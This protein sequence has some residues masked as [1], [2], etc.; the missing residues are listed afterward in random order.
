MKEKKCPVMPYTVG[1]EI[2]LENFVESLKLA[3]S[4][5]ILSCTAQTMYI[6]TFLSSEGSVLFH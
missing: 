6:I 2:A 1:S 3:L 4:L 5:S